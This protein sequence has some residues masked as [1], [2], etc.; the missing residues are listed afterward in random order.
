MTSSLQA[1]NL[2]PIVARHFAALRPP[3]QPRQST[4]VRAA[5]LGVPVGAGALV[6]VLVALG[7]DLRD[8]TSQVL[9][10]TALLVG[11]MLTLFVFLTNLRIKIS[12]SATYAFRTRLQQLVGGAAVSSLYVACLA[13]LVALEIATVASVQW[14]RDFPQQP[15]T[16]AVLV[17]TGCHLAL[18]LV[19]VIRRLFGVYYE[20]FQSDFSPSVDDANR[21]A[22][23]TSGKREV[24][25]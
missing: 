6:G 10:A 19:T 1:F 20:L 23:G 7:L 24:K 14:L 16:A 25:G 8:G 4:A 2:G 11:A 17:S 22:A 3:G 9:A 18:T 5:M 13:M 21:M 15:L 12:E